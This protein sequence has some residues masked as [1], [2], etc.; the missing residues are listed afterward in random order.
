MGLKGRVPGSTSA[1]RDDVLRLAVAFGVSFVGDRMLLTILGVEARELT[2]SDGAAGLVALFLIAPGLFGPA[3]GAVVDRYDR[4]RSYVATCLFMC[5]VVT[6]AVLAHEIRSPLPLY[7]VA[8]SYGV[9]FVVFGAIETAM[10]PDIVSQG[11]VGA[12]NALLTSTRESLRLVAP[13]IGVGIYVATGGPGGVVLVDLA[14]FIVAIVI[15][16]TIRVRGETT[17][18]RSQDLPTWIQDV[19]QG[20]GYARASPAIRRLITFA[21]LAFG[22]IGFLE[23]ALYASVTRGLDWPAYAIA[24]LSIAQG[25]GAIVAGVFYTRVQSAVG[26]ARTAGFALV[27]VGVGAA[28]L[29]AGVPALSIG[30]AALLSIGMTWFFIAEATCLQQWS[31]PGWRGRVFGA[32]TAAVTVVQLASIAIGAGLSELVD[33]RYLIAGVVIGSVLAGA[34]LVVNP[35]SQPVPRS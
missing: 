27:I 1:E 22:G 6:L 21:M 5:A 30:G 15:F 31:E 19:R 20:V 8:A 23:T 3:V 4:Q 34:G 2:G 12:T 9:A 32:A 13:A 11:A 17:S 25:V 18:G 7:F 24:T 29:A 33:W 28:P 14:T 16:R 10:V 26:A 35:P